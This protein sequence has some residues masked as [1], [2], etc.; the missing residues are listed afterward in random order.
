MQRSWHKALR[1][2]FI[3]NIRNESKTVMESHR[4][5]FL[6]IPTQQLI[7]QFPALFSPN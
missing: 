6:H 2:Y 7:V 1:L 4:L 5:P 3:G